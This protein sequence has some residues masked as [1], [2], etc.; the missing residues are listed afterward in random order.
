MNMHEALLSSGL[1]TKPLRATP[2]HVYTVEEQDKP[3]SRTPK[4]TRKTRARRRLSDAARDEET[5]ILLI[6][7]KHATPRG[8]VARN[9][10]NMYKKPANTA[11]WRQKK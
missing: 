10:K 3:L 11:V 8:D 5:R 7:G 2:Q 9:V 4:P 1:T 6:T